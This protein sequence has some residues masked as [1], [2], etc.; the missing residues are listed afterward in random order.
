MEETYDDWE[1]S[2]ENSQE[3]KARLNDKASKNIWVAVIVF[4]VAFVIYG[5]YKDDECV[6][7]LEEIRQECCY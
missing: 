7:A 4:I 6:S 3:E 2:Y 1:K 5:L